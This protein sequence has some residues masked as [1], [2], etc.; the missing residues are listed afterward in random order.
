[1]CA[2]TAISHVFKPKRFA[3]TCSAA[4]SVLAA[5]LGHWVSLRFGGIF[6]ALPVVLLAS[7]TLIGRR[8]GDEPAAEDGEG[9]VVGACACAGSAVLLALLLPRVAGALALWLVLGCCSTSS[10]CARADSA[11]GRTTSSS[12]HRASSMSSMSSLAWN[13][14]RAASGRMTQSP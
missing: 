9:R 10:R 2:F 13:C 4:P 7:L 3:G 11:P 1:V 6:M 12:A 5:L 14:R 8:D